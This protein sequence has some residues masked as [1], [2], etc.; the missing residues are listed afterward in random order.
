MKTKKEKCRNHTPHRQKGTFYR[1]KP[2][3]HLPELPS[4]RFYIPECRNAPK[5]NENAIQKEENTIFSKENIILLDKSLL[6]ERKEVS[7]RS[8]IFVIIPTIIYI[9]NQWRMQ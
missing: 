3:C 7:L 8:E 1:R 6:F 2:N 4:A 5:T 9:N